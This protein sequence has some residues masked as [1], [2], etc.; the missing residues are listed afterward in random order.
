MVTDEHIGPC[1]TKS[2]DLLEKE[3]YEV[4]DHD[5]KAREETDAFK[6]KYPVEAAPQTFIDENRIGGYD[7]FRVCLRLYKHLY[8][9]LILF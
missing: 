8:C 3:D 2:K 7:G 9:H 1:G 4:E 6:K 5:L